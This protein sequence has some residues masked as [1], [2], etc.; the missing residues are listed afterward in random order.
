MPWDD[1]R[2]KISMTLTWSRDYPSLMLSID[3]GFEA[4]IE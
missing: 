4:E 2:I 3:S 1:H